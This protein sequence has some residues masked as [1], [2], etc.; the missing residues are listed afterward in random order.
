VIL[1]T[2]LSLSDAQ[3]RALSV[4]PGHRR[5]SSRRPATRALFVTDFLSVRQRGHFYRYFTLLA[6]VTVP[7]RSTHSSA[8]ACRHGVRLFGPDEAGPNLVGCAIESAPSAQRLRG[9]LDVDTSWS[10]RNREVAV[11]H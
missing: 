10:S 5:P 7:G 9:T 11:G 3:P 8:S 6:T 1:R 4:E 2:L